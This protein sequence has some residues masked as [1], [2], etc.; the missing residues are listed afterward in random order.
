METLD[1]ILGHLHIGEPLFHYG[2]FVTSAIEGGVT[3]TNVSKSN[4][5]V[6][7]LHAD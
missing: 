2:V 4:N 3:R 6:I 5:K 1:Q 7:F